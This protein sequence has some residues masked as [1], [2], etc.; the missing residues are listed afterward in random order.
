MR[1]INNQGRLT[2]SSNFNI[3]MKQFN[4][5]NN[6]EEKQ[7]VLQLCITVM[8][9]AFS[10]FA[11]RENVLDFYRTQ[12][13]ALLN[14][15][16][17]RTNSVFHSHSTVLDIVL[18]RICY[19]FVHLNG[20]YDDK[21]T[22]TQVKEA[23]HHQ[24][25]G[26]LRVLLGNEIIIK[27]KTNTISNNINQIHGAAFAI[28]H[29][30]NI[31]IPNHI[32]LINC[33]L[34]SGS[35]SFHNGNL[36]VIG[37]A[38]ATITGQGTIDL[39]HSDSIGFASGDSSRVILSS[40]SK[41]YATV[42]NATV[43]VN[44]EMADGYADGNDASVIVNAGCGHGNGRGSIVEAN[45]PKA[46]AIANKEGSQIY[47][48]NE[49]RGTVIDGTIH[50][51]DDSYTQIIIDK[52]CITGKVDLENGNNTNIVSF[53]EYN[54]NLTNETEA[55]SLLKYEG[56]TFLYQNPAKDL[57]RIFLNGTIQEQP[58]QHSYIYNLV[59]AEILIKY[60]K[61]M[62][63]EQKLDLL[64]KMYDNTSGEEKE[65]IKRV[66]LVVKYIQNDRIDPVTI[67]QFASILSILQQ[68]NVLTTLCRNK[69][70]QWETFNNLFKKEFMR[71]P[72]QSELR[73][74]IDDRDTIIINTDPIMMS[75]LSTNAQ[76]YLL[77]RDQN[78]QIKKYD[79]YSQASMDNF[80]NNKRVNPM[81]R[82][83][84]SDTDVKPL[85]ELFT[86]HTI[87]LEDK[88]KQ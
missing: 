46:R 62:S 7:K 68:R 4:Q 63:K 41:G 37:A 44:N 6:I 33:N 78:Q 55:S 73:F 16:G 23:L 49:A 20:G 19:L 57:Y 77:L 56:K 15:I 9:K 82:N 40:P 27:S 58:T 3:R 66:E 48:T 45:G 65:K 14:I 51:A 79:L 39:I 85:Y 38:T 35:L 87:N 8:H 34:I 10:C 12:D 29:N 69:Q 13:P 25:I 31:I 32:T 42:P 30:D 43:I 22:L 76:N 21:T 74:I 59:E 81:T 18:T 86:A 83:P 67:S 24:T 11:T 72:E 2:V 75:P 26:T 50:L 47:L 71:N 80:S 64:K 5:S 53:L 36:N 17:Y 88:A 28:S 54:N 52:E 70:I 84:I 60:Q 61:C 1:M